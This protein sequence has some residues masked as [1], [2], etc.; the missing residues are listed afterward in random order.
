M[1][2]RHLG[3]EIGGCRRHHDQVAVAR[4]PDMTGV[5]LAVGIEQVGIGALAGQRARRERRDELLRGPGQ[6]AADADV[7][8]LQPADQ[9]KRFVGRDA[10][11]DDQGDAGFVR[12]AGRAR[13]CLR[14]G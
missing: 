1:A 11:A 5:E 4:Q 2:V 3:H 8:L 12:G 13:R 7:A 10:A 9:V 6:H 14:S